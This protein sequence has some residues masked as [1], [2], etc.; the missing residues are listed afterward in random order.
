MISHT[1]R[2]ETRSAAW[3]NVRPEIS[4]TILV[5][6]GSLIGTI[7]GGVEEEACWASVAVV[8]RLAE[9]IVHELLVENM[10]VNAKWFRE[11]RHTDRTMWTAKM[12]LEQRYSDS[13][14]TDSYWYNSWVGKRDILPYE[15]DITTTNNYACTK[16]LTVYYGL[17]SCDLPSNYW[18]LNRTHQISSSISHQTTSDFAQ[19]F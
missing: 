18:A 4:S 5:I 6:V 15:M 19:K 14:L 11:R 7:G 9:L 17:L 1:F 13:R 3:S 12:S 2:R 16:L 8:S 10:F